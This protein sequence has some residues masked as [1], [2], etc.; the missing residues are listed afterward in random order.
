M[1]RGVGRVGPISPSCARLLPPHVTTSPLARIASE[2]ATPAEMSR[3]SVSEG[4]ATGL[5]ELPVPVRPSWP[6]AL[7]PQ[8]QT[9]PLTSARL[10]RAPAA[11]VT[12]DGPTGI[13]T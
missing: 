9:V 10:C 3:A 13:E 11:M 6:S 8:D 4:I 7:L 5:D 2:K 12:A 1:T